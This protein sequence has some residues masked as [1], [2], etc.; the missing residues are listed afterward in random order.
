MVW[1]LK[2]LTALVILSVASL[3]SGCQP[4][5]VNRTNYD[6]IEV[7][8]QRKDVE[9]ILGPP[10]GSYQGVLSWTT[11][12]SHTVISVVLDGEGRVTEKSADNL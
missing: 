2:R 10:A 6:R 9:A 12:H 1:K 8:M 3:V 4:E 5:R 11:N 7:G